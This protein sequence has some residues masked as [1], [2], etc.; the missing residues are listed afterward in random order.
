[1]D[2]AIICKLS[3]NIS[4]RSQLQ[5]AELTGLA[6]AAAAASYRVLADVGALSIQCAQRA[7]ADD[8]DAVTGKPAAA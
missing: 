7:A 1:M 2:T 6:A 3:C 5:A 4:L 8:W